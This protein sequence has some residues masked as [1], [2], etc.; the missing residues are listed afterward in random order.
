MMPARQCHGQRQ[1]PEPPHEHQ[2]AQQH[3]AGIREVVPKATM[4]STYTGDFNDSAKAKEATQAQI[5]QC[6]KVI[7]PYLGGATDAAA[8][9]A[10]EGGAPASA[11]GTRPSS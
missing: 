5:S 10:N 11:S 2:P 1:R 9:L 7:Y 4:T 6:I 8:Q 3:L